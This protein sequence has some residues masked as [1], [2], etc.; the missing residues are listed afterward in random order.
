[1]PV[2][3][4]ITTQLLVPRD[5]AILAKIAS[6]RPEELAELRNPIVDVATLL[7]V[8]NIGEKQGVDGMARFMISEGSSLAR[9]MPNENFNSYEEFVKSVEAGTSLLSAVEGIR[10]GGGFTF[11]TPVCPFRIAA[12]EYIRRIGAFTKI[13]EEV[14]DYYNKTF[15]P[16]AVESFCLIHQAFRDEVAKKISVK[17]KPIKIAQIA[18]KGFNGDIKTIPNM[19]LSTVLEKA[20]IDETTLYTHLRLNTC[21]FM[22]Y[23][24]D[25]V[26]VG[27]TR[28]NATLR[29]SELAPEKEIEES[30]APMEVTKE[31]EEEREE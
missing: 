30:I 16:S 10:H 29:E 6:G 14:T 26:G 15:Q 8:E 31:E 17:Q 11:I 3:Q 4:E 18:C 13:H 1:M 19:W 23:M 12:D 5:R 2:E 22:A 21:V 9:A 20:G 27:E 25:V 24:E 28:S 7:F